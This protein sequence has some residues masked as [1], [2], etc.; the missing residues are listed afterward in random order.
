MERVTYENQDTGFRVVRLGNV[1]GGKRQQGRVTVVGTM[2]NVGPGTRVRVTG[3]WVTDERHGEQL[4]ADSLVI[5]EPETLDGLERYLASGILPGIG[6]GLAKRI[7][8]TF[9]TDTLKVLDSAPEK[10]GAVPG[11]GPKRVAELRSAWTEQRAE[12]TVMVLLQSHG[13]ALGLARRILRFYGDRTSEMVQS[14]P[15]RLITDI[16]GVGFKT[17]DSIAMAFG[18]R[19][20]DPERLKAGLIFALT[21]ASERGHT[22][23][24]REA[25]L[26]QSCERLSVE[27]PWLEVALAQL[28]AG[29]QVVIEG[30]RVLLTRFFSAETEICEQLARRLQK[31]PSPLQ[32]AAEAVAA[33][34]QESQMTLAEEQRAAVEMV[35]VAR[36]A[37]ITG[38]PGVGKTTL[39]RAL[40]RLCEGEQRRLRLAAPTGRAA[41]RLAEATGRDA[42]TLHRLLEFD[43]RT[44]GFVRG[45]ET[46]L[47]ADVVLVDETSMVDL[48]ML[49]SL[50]AALPEHARLVLV[51]DADQLP[52]VGPGAVLRDL[53]A[54]G[55]IPSVRL[56]RVYRQSHQSAIVENA[57]RI[58]AGLLPEG[59]E[60]SREGADFFV[61]TR[62]EVER[63]ADDVVELVV[64]RIPQKFGFDP[65]RDIQ[66]LSPMHRGPLGTV[67]L[68]ARL[69]AALNG[70]GPAM[71]LRGAPMRVGDKV[72]QTR[73]DYERDVFNG[74]VGWVQ[75]LDP[76][77][78][79]LTVEYDGRL[80]RYD[81]A[82]M[83]ALV[84][85]YAVSVHKSQG[86]EYPA[87]VL[88]LMTTHYVM[89]TRNL[90][91]TAV[92]RARKLCVLVT[93]PKAMR[94][95]V[96]ED[97]R[98]ERATWLAQRLTAAVLSPECAAPREPLMLGARA[99]A[100]P[101]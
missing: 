45:V 78:R 33:F 72:M 3:R 52:S 57:H 82:E 66:V 62:R 47:E 77:G 89:L 81:E 48:P 85:A 31:A 94:L 83:D 61:V 2:P 39:V 40:V 8:A 25:L 18:I 80:V 55:V 101:H 36:V 53:L 51:G 7:V 97:R 10:L 30:D 24:L 32:R 21:E 54:S 74:D 100:A 1:D 28:W 22:L 64:T 87:V 27:S 35:T 26:A 5:V 17:A 65:R 29:G 4:R 42:S 67:E 73:N 50:L 23:M 79:R 90:L 34:E 44:G 68:N 63:A 11:I 75:S 37:V 96:S 91:Y 56:G 41:K 95:A 58:Q 49:S 70:E 16:W 69:Q 46:P 20:D 14:S 60:P 86:S 76:E 71:M 43:P 59:S 15:Y 92:T 9:G 38:G 88:P 98:E 19:K 6:A 93:E 13:V 84:L 12:S 99:D